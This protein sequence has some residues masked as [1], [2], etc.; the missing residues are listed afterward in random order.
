MYTLVNMVTLWHS[1]TGI[2]NHVISLLIVFETRCTAGA[3][4]NSTL[5]RGGCRD[6]RYSCLHRHSLQLCSQNK[7]IGLY[8]WLLRIHLWETSLVRF[9]LLKTNYNLCC[10]FLY[11]HRIVTITCDNYDDNYFHNFYMSITNKSIVLY[12]FLLSCCASQTACLVFP[13]IS[14][15]GV[16][17]HCN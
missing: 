17:G 6:T 9:L 11:I 14:I 1:R 16:L 15:L 7:R 2:V 3:Q 4:F 8:P 10:C 5:S 12:N 13:Q